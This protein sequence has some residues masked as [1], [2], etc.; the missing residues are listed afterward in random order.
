M[1]KES[2]NNV[3]ILTAILYIVIGI[4]FIVFKNDILS[5]VMT[6]IGV[7][8]IVKAVFA[9]FEKAR[10]DA[11][12]CGVIGLTVILGGW[13]FLSIVM[14]VFGALIAISGITSLMQALK[15]KEIKQLIVP[16]ITIVIGILVIVSHWVIAD[17]FFII[18]GVIFVINGILGLLSTIS[19]K[20][21]EN[22]D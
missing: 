3:G 8:F 11:A 19:G 21:A 15:T 7:L 16:V 12:V 2:L 18:F 20:D 17:W 9:A 4:L 22:H 14:I 13:L 10:I 5:W 6:A 1:K